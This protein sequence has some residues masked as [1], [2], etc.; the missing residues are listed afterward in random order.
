MRTSRVHISLLLTLAIIALYSMK[1][2]I[3]MKLM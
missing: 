3:R 1:R 2:L